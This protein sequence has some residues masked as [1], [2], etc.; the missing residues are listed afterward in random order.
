MRQVRSLKPSGTGG[1]P[2]ASP[3]KENAEQ[4]KKAQEKADKLE[5]AAERQRKREE[6][7]ENWESLYGGKG[8]SCFC[9]DS[10]VALAEPSGGEKIMVPLRSLRPGDRLTSPDGLGAQVVC[11]VESRTCDGLAWLVDLSPGI[12]ATPWHPVSIKPPALLESNCNESE[13]TFPLHLGMPRERQCKAVYNLVLDRSHVCQIGGFWVACLGH[14]LKA[15]KVRHSFWGGQPVLD[16]LKRLP[17]WEWGRVVIDSGQVLRDA[18]G[19]ACGLR[20]EEHT[21]EGDEDS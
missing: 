5:A 1:G 7:A 2:S 15:D 17:G 20:T 21:R 10:L 4:E 18:N 3:T 14:G 6:E 19:L 8:G 16:A 13:W 12:R 9:G 11:L